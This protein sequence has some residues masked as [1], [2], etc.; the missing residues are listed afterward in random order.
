LI[1]DIDD[2]GADELVWN[3]TYGNNVNRTY[4]ANLR[5]DNQAI[6]FFP[7]HDLGTNWGMYD[8]YMGD[9]NGGG[10][11]LIWCRTNDKNRTY[12]GTSNGNGTYDQRGPYTRSES[13]W[14]NYDIY[15]G[16]ADNNTT[17][18][19]LFNYPGPNINRLYVSPSTG[20]GGFNSSFSGQD[21]PVNQDWR[22]YKL[23]LGDVDGD[24]IDDITWT[25]HGNGDITSNVFTALGTNSGVY[26]FTPV[27]QSSPFQATWSQFESFL[28]DIN[29]D[30]KKDM[31]WV[32]PGSTTEYYVALAK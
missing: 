32:K 16:Y 1:G 31:L 22:D 30:N 17:T 7:Y 26:D 24:G 21:H 15:T 29:G 12:T 23:L 4:T 2:D 28:I 11:D 8:A 20:N 27:K 19:L 14:S 9:I 10:A 3:I 18:D 13:G 5:A 6:G 25:N